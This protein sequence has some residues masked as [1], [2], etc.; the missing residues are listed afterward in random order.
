MQDD[1]Q[2][3]LLYCLESVLSGENVPQKVVQQLL[4]LAE[5][6]DHDDQPLPL[7]NKLLGN[8][9]ERFHA[10]AKALHYKVGSSWL[11]GPQVNESHGN[12]SQELEFVT[13]RIESIGALI[14]INH[15]LQVRLGSQ[16]PFQKWVVLINACVAS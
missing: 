1:Y 11:A 3:D 14:S 5:F 15:E 4:D 9:A 2:D 7:P 13:N 12:A 16:L 6:M 10:F 8:L